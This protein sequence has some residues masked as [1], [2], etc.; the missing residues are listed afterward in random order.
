MD[1]GSLTTSASIAWSERTSTVETDGP[2]YV[3]NRQNPHDAHIW[4]KA[5]NYVCDFMTVAVTAKNGNHAL[6]MALDDKGGALDTHHLSRI[7][8]SI[9]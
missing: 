3:R 4:P 2:A 7:H 6:T 1:H 8:R 9:R 5:P